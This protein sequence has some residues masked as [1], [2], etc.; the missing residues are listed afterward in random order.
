MS[1]QTA[2]QNVNLAG[3]SPPRPQTVNTIWPTWSGT[4]DP[5]NPLSYGSSSDGPT[6]SQIVGSANFQTSYQDYRSKPILSECDTNAEDSTYGSRLTH[7]IGNHSAY[8]E[9]LDPDIQTLDTPNPDTQLVYSNLESLQLT[10]ESRQYRDQW[11]RSR[12]PASIATAPAGGERRL[13]C[14]DC[15]KICRTQSEL[16][17]HALRHSLPFECDVS[18]CS[19]DKGFTS[20]N[21]L[22]RHKRTVHNDRTVSGRTFVCSIGNCAKK[23][24]VW[25]R[26]DNFRSHLERMHRKKYSANDDLSE[27]VYRPIPSQGLEGVGGSAMAYVQAQEQLPGLAHPSSILS[28]RGYHGDRR[29]SQPQP[30]IS[31]LSRGPASISTDRD[32]AGL[33]PVRESDENFIRPEILNGS[34]PLLQNRWPP[35]AASEEDAPGDD[36]MTS[37]SEQRHDSAPDAMDDVQQTG[38]SEAD[39]PSADEDPRS[40]QP[41]IRM[42]DADEAQRT[43]R[44]VSLPD[45]PSFDYSHANPEATYELLDKLPKHLIASYVKKHLPGM[46]DEDETPKPDIPSTKSQG[47]SHKCQDCDKTFPRLC[48]LKK[49]QKRHSKPYGCTFVDCTKTFGSKNDWKRH[50]SI[51][52]YQLE[53]WICNCTKSNSS[54]LCGK[55]CHRR[56]SFRNHLMKEHE[57][58]DQSVLEEK[59]DTC[60]KGRHCDAHFWCGFCE[61]TIQIKE[62]DNTWT[63]RCD[64]IDDHFSGRGDMPK[65]HISEWVHEKA[66]SAV[67]STF[68]ETTSESSPGSSIPDPKS[69]QTIAS[70]GNSGEDRRIPKDTYM[71]ICCNCNNENS[72]SHNTACFECTRRK[73]NSCSVH[74][75]PRPNDS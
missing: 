26:A 38:T 65:R 30:G 11:S 57:I 7:S 59:L 63:K 48:E 28:F 75:L 34:G 9:D 10:N 14:K 23:N 51:Q 40:Q 55:V 62:S 43:P 6:R 12:P 39:L 3:L 29:A 36:V 44:A 50:E 56:E 8:G 41:D 74:T 71:W 18:G 25:P 66:H 19:R 61:N 21:D 49:H 24:K 1:P 32:V 69:P 20:K 64:H 5:W 47:H 4:D 70:L 16:R 52:H 35:S 67:S 60:R 68:Q 2:Q 45:R 73:C 13:R 72:F 27:F 58:S 42:A 46:R 31:S 22:D 17:K 33:T 15:Q 53:T 54:E 37:D